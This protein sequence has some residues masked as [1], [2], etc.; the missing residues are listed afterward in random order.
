L[1]INPLS[2][3][4]RS[5]TAR[6]NAVASLDFR[7]WSAE[8]SFEPSPKP[9][10][11]GYILIDRRID[12]PVPGRPAITP[13]NK[14]T[15]CQCRRRVEGREARLDAPFPFDPQTPNRAL[16]RLLTQ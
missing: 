12:R 2:L 15:E 9:F 3:S 14:P 4:H 16:E 1:A 11:S 7:L 5:Q 8:H 6:L 10:P 13:H